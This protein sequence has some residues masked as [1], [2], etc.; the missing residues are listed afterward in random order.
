MSFVAIFVTAFI[1]GLV[2]ATVTIVCHASQFGE[3]PQFMDC[4]RVYDWEAEDEPS[5]RK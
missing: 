3:C 4:N 5:C 2:S 1:A